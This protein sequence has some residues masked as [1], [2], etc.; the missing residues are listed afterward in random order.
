MGKLIGGLTTIVGWSSFATVLALGIVLCYAGMKGYVA[1]DK[2][3]KM[4]AIAYGVE[5]VSV[6]EAQN[7]A[8]KK[9]GTEK[10]SLESVELHRAAMTGDLELREN[11][12]RDM[13][14]E[15]K[16][17]QRSL[18]EEKERF[19]QYAG[20]FKNELSEERKK[21]IEEGQRE[22][23]TIIESMKPKQAKEQLFLK[24]KEDKLDVVIATM[25]KME[26]SKRAK[27]LTEFK[28]TED[29]EALAKI[30]EGIRA[31]AEDTESK[32]LKA[33]ETP[34]DTQ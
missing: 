15:F 4:A 19:D 25:K 22:F 34:S 8:T 5:M 3:E 11:I 29:Q 16:K 13:V 21:K 23:Q 26:E 12:I 31:P 1:P 6:H 32:T 7:S 18:E 10:P 9:A 24:F 2:V 17:L 33:L 27:V 14:S 28:T 20:A 30:L